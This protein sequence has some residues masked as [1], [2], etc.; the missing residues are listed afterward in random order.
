MREPRAIER[1]DCRTTNVRDSPIIPNNKP[2]KEYDITR[3][4]LYIIPFSKTLKLDC[5]LIGIAI[6][7]GP[8]IP[9]QC[10]EPRK[11]NNN[12]ENNI[13]ITKLISL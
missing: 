6:T 2:I 5:D 10:T 13:I 4:K 9:T 12:A 11:P 1:F 7:I 8:H 3:P